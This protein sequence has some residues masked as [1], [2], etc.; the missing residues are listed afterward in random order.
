MFRVP[1]QLENSEVCSIEIVCGITKKEI[2]E[3]LMRIFEEL[4]MEFSQ[5]ENHFET[6]AGDVL[7]EYHGESCFDLRLFKVVFPNEELLKKF[8]EMLMSKRAGG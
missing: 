6:E 7:I 5:C 3:I 1:L 2:I 4:E 8:R